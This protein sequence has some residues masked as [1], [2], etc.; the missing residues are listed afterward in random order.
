MLQRWK[1]KWKLHKE[2][3]NYDRN[4]HVCKLPRI[5]FVFPHAIC[6]DST[7]VN[8]TGNTGI[9][10][11]H[12]HL[13][14]IIKFWFCSYNRSILIKHCKLFS[15]E[16][17]FMFKGKMY[18]MAYRNAITSKRKQQKHRAH[19]L[20]AH[21]QIWHGE[22]PLTVVLQSTSS[23]FPSDRFLTLVKELEALACD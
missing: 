18:L 16:W 15:H 21:G 6:K 10:G 5:Q 13:E 20:L 12:P 23:L 22:Q 1:A 11:K 19:Q 9:D 4:V 7:Q 2:I 3:N 14:E 17:I 8:W